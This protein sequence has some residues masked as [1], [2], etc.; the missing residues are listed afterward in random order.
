M[1]NGKQ[2]CR[3]PGCWQ[4]G[5][6]LGHP[7]QTPPVP[8]EG[9]EPRGSQRPP[10]PGQLLQPQPPPLHSQLSR[11]L[12]KVSPGHSGSHRQARGSPACASHPHPPRSPRPAPG[13]RSE[14]PQTAAPPVLICAK[15]PRGTVSPGG[16][17]AMARRGRQ[18]AWPEA[19]VPHGSALPCPLCSW[20]GA[21]AG[22]STRVCACGAPCMADACAQPRLCASTR[23]PLRQSACG[24]RY[25]AAKPQRAPP[26]AELSVWPQPRRSLSQPATG[27]APALPCPFLGTCP[28]GRGPQ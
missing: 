22:T 10:V 20:A 15:P 26:G 19:L 7:P 13:A 6:L 16:L 25:G 5:A 9:C 24:R 28:Q 17:E 12:T 8:R 3:G 4:R 27:R 21:S 1:P 18:L 23:V 14:T 11:A 2:P